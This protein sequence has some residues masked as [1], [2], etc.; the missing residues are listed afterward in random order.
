[1]FLHRPRLAK[2]PNWEDQ[3][4]I[5]YDLTNLFLRPIIKPDLLPPQLMEENIQSFNDI[6]NLI[7][8]NYPAILRH[9]TPMMVAVAFGFLFALLSLVIGISFC[10]CCNKSSKSKNKKSFPKGFLGTLGFLL[11][12][13]ATLGVAWFC[14]GAVKFQ[15][16]LNNINQVR[17]ILI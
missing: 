9:N 13:M 10:C 3:G 6:S 12:V 4:G 8:D 17:G 5:V 2:M 16:G 1:M 14:V 11:I 15:S 7:I